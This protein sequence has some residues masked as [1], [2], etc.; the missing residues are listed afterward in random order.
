MS[1][2]FP[3]A[4]CSG[5]PAP[6]PRWR[7]WG[8]CRGTRSGGRSRTS[9]RRAD[10][11]D[12]RGTYQAGI[13]TPSQDELYFTA[14][15]LTSTGKAAVQRMLSQWTT[16]AERMTQGLEAAGGRRAPPQPR[17]AADGHR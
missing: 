8:R 12:F 4:G 6:A 9:R 2:A 3:G 7:A 16:A 15:D 17:G 13:T 1:E 5:G 10:V 14:L 11:V